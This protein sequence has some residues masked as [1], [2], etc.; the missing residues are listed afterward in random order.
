MA[1]AAGQD[2]AAGWGWATTG[3]GSGLEESE[4]MAA[5]AA[6]VAEEELGS[7]ADLAHATMSRQKNPLQTRP[8]MG[9]RWM[10]VAT[11]GTR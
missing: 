5:Q 4:V 10:H 9:V 7:G 1:A 8:V 2:W 11:H 6:V 3:A